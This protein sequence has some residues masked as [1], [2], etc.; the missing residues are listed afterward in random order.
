MSEQWTESELAAPEDQS[1]YESPSTASNDDGAVFRGELVRAMRTTAAVE[2]IRIAEDSEKRRLAHVERVR[3]RQASEADRM[4]ELASDDMKAIETWA[5]GEMKRIKL[6]K[7]R[8]AKDLNED[9]DLSL[10]EHS[11]RID[12]EIEGIETSIAAYLSEVD[13]FFDGLDQ[14]TDLVLIA[15]QAARR[16]IFPTLDAVAELDAVAAPEEAPAEVAV[17]DTLPE[18]PVAE[19]DGVAHEGADDAAEPAAVG[20]MDPQAEPEAVES[21]APAPEASPEAVPVGAS[22][23]V[24]SGEAVETPEPVAA[25]TAS[26]HGSSLFESVSVMRP[27]SWLRRDSSDHSNSDS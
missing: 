17:E 12:R 25:A 1:V 4:R 27:M 11:S 7:E 22:E 6:E 21:W 3:A 13:A 8:R 20:V 18:T 19:G 26:N 24:E 9:L 2:R 10:A 15:K 23:D 14:E 5:A 16:P